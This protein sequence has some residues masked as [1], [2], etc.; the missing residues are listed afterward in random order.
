MNNSVTIND[1]VYYFKGDFTIY[2]FCFSKGINLPCFCYHEK[3]SIAGNCRICLVEANGAL[4]VSCAMPLVS[5]MVIFTDSQRVRRSR[6]GVLEFLL[7]NHPLDCPICDQGGECDLQDISLIFGSDRGRFYE[8][9]KKSVDN[10]NC[11]GP[12]IKTVMTR[13]I[14]CTRCVRYLNEVS[15]VFDLGTLG[16]GFSMEIGTFIANSWG[17]ELSGNIIDLCPVGALTS[18]PFAY[19]ARP[20]E[21]T[22]FESIDVLDALASTIRID[23]ANN[24]VLRV[25]PVLSESVNEEWLSNKA[26]FAYDSFV[27]QRSHYPR[28]KIGSSFVVVSWSVAIATFFDVLSFEKF[29]FLEV[30][31]GPFLDLE[32][33][34]SVRSFFYSLGCANINYEDNCTTFF[35]Y[36]YSFLLTSTLRSLESLEL[37]FF[38]GLN[39]RTEAPLLCSR[40]R[41]SFI[42]G[43]HPFLCFAFGGSLDYVSFPIFS[44][45]NSLRSVKNFMEGRHNFWSDFVFT[46][47]SVLGKALNVNFSIF[48]KC[49]IFVGA[50]FFNRK[51]CC[52]IMEALGYFMQ[53]HKDLFR[54]S[55]NVVAPFLGRISAFE[56]GA[57]P[58]IHGSQNLVV[59]RAKGSFLY[60]VGTGAVPFSGLD[61]TF[62]KASSFVVYQGSFFEDSAFFNYVD[63]ILPVSIYT[64]RVSTYINVEGRVRR[65]RKAITPSRLIATDREILQAF[66]YYKTS[67]FPGNFSMLPH[68]AYLQMFFATVI[69]YSCIFFLTMTENTFKDS[70]YGQALVDAPFAAVTLVDYKNLKIYNTVIARDF[71]HYY[72]SEQFSR[73]SK[74][75]SICFTKANIHS[76]YKGASDF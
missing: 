43:D 75:L 51:D 44:L 55:W 7:I 64:E 46:P 10:L 41:K 37:C 76:F 27:L 66:W 31:V 14:H 12:L 20:W 71:N 52:F 18:M 23:V 67:F 29:H 53:E 5:D 24:K 16:R 21:L 49:S 15:G 54:F 13:C 57:L 74:I 39:I 73:N 11:C 32:S 47:E 58:G 70:S 68:F 35:D 40:L 19:T 45:G 4:A 50:S 8:V 42:S 17:H 22:A 6:E 69:D 62:S 3:L 34:Y 65:T 33:V 26:R 28:L 38:F 25:V 63:L 36:R 56:L 1:I 60:L 30:S 59:N 9:R 72:N 48:E 61:L 2:Q